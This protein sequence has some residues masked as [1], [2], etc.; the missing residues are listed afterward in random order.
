MRVALEPEHPADMPKLIQGLKLLAQAD[1]CVETFQ[2]Q[3]GEH[4]IL[5]AGELHGEVSGVPSLGL[6]CGRVLMANAEVSER[7]S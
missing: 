5:T 3:T 4:V 1:P 6:C 2:Q 7:S